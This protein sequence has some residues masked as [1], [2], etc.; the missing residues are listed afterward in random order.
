M[1]NEEYPHAVGQLRPSQM[2]YAFGVGAVVDL[3]SL[4][5]LVMGIDDWPTDP[6]LAKEVSEERLLRAVRWVLGPQ[7]QKLVTPPAAPDDGG[8]FRPFDASGRVG[9]PVATFPRWVVCPDCR[10]LAPLESGLFELRESPYHP[11]R[12]HYY[13]ANCPKS[14]GK[15]PPRVLP[16]RFMV[17]CENG[18]LDDF[19]WREFVHRGP[20]D[21]N[22]ALRLFERGPSGE[23][24]EV[25]VR[26]DA[27]GKVRRLSEAFGNAGKRSMPICRGRR[28]H[29]RDYEEEC[30]LQVRAILLGASNLWFPDVLTTLAIP[31][32]SGLLTQLVEDQWAILANAMSSQN[33]QLLRQVGVLAAFAGHSDDEIWRAIQDRRQQGAQGDTAEP[34]DLKGPE[35]RMFSQ[36][37]TAPQ[38]KDFRL[39]AVTVPAEFAQ[40]IQQVVLVERLREVNAM[41]G[42]TRIDAPGEID[43]S[44]DATGPRRMD[45][46]RRAPA[47]VPATEV[48]GEGIFVQVRED[49]LNNWLKLPAVRK[50]DDEFRESHR[51]WRAARRLEPPEL[52]YPGMRYVLLHSFAH[53]LM[54]QFALNCG[55]SAASMRERIYAR[56]LG[57]SEAHP[58]PMA[59][60]L[61]Y[62]SAPD[63]EG[64]L[65]GLVSLGEP[66]E[67]V[68]HI[69]AALEDAKLCASDPLCAEQSPSSQGLTLHA[70]ACH[71]CLL[72][73]ETSCESGNRYLDRSVLVPTVERSDLAFFGSDPS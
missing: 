11:E 25:E 9:V 32:Q 36:P 10:L 68:R 50:R 37:A 58:E 8:M 46:S 29:L 6:G 31:A 70:A 39:R 42:F 61:I 38:S 48:R 12:T 47:W 23:A 45:I 41:I 54:R 24:R 53:A 44:G 33:V 15:T 43:E 62:T 56:G 17:A 35:W 1:T 30:G 20:T 5:V 63:S 59:G 18:H 2:V 64:T 3:P 57:E 60:V 65:G 71:A 27:C 26:C 14:R 72:A 21:C 40:Q 22:G 52:G 69:L 67:L 73:P 49:S 16:A 19:P 34:V 4:S 51:R 28:P 7:V 66:E 55:Y 13:H